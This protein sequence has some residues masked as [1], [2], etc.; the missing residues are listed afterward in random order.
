MRQSWWVID[1]VAGALGIAAVVAIAW[2]FT[3]RYWAAGG[4]LVGRVL[5]VVALVFCLCTL[6]WLGIETVYAAWRVTESNVND[7][8]C[9]NVGRFAHDHLPDNAVLLC[10]E[11]S[12]EEHLTIMFHA[13]RTCYALRPARTDT[14]ARQVVQAGG[15][16][17]LVTHQELPFPVVYGEGKR[18]LT[19]Y[20]WQPR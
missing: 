17:Y 18:G 15:I 4:G 20:L 10:E 9:M 12:G 1:H 7:P 11:R 3:R 5:Q 6:G 8:A 14:M 13:G 16:P 19:I 2:I